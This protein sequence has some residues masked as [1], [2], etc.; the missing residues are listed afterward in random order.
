MI[1]Q[2]SDHF[3]IE[4]Q[5]HGRHGDLKPENILWFNDSRSSEPGYSLGT[6]KISDFG[7]TRFHATLSKSQINTD[8][9]GGSPTYRAPEY[10]VL[11]EVA[12]SYD[13]W[14]LACVFLEFTTWYL[15]GWT[16]VDK[17]SSSRK[18]EDRNPLIKEDTFF[19]H[20]QTPN[21]ISAVAKKSVAR[22]VRSL[23]EHEDTSDFII[24]L[25]EFLETGLLRMHPEIRKKCCDT[26]EKLRG[27]YDKC[28]RNPDYCLK[29]TNKPPS[30]T[31][32]DLSHLGPVELPRPHQIAKR[33]ADDGP[34]PSM[35]RPG[36]PQ[37][38]RSSEHRVNTLH[39][40]ATE[41]DWGDIEPGTSLPNSSRDAD[42][43]QHHTTPTQ[44]GYRIDTENPKNINTEPQDSKTTGTLVRGA[45]FSHTDSRGNQQAA[46]DLRLDEREGKPDET[47]FL[48]NLN[49][50]GAISH[51][52]VVQTEHVEDTSWLKHFHAVKQQLRAFCW[53]TFAAFQVLLIT[54][55][56]QASGIVIGIPQFRKEFDSAH[57][58][59]YVLDA[60]WEASFSAAPVAT[61]VIGPLASGQLA[62][63]I[64]L[65]RA[66]K[67]ALVISLAVIAMEIAAT[68]NDMFFAGKLVK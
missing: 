28:I 33:R 67:V 22:E 64:G 56:Y 14:C 66:I 11:N 53:A 21:T 29:T 44:S 47:S 5:K 61:Q 31:N 60:R 15:K 18:T 52:H 51:H 41:L 16:A 42:M 8:G 63:L 24:D 36:S 6:L 50:R 45:V 34:P 54:Y 17:F 62:D 25:V 3:S 9:I 59:N 57:A 40:E 48:T 2:G 32:T 13:I 30:R 46:G 27:F 38:F 43:I 19:N 12:Q 65:K 55:E 10:D 4:R 23:Y 39:E 1:H 35:A 49:Q 26:V 37:T 58:R 68:T 7:L 20:V